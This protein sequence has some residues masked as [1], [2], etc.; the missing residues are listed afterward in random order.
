MTV[1]VRLAREKKIVSRARLTL[2]GHRSAVAQLT[3]ATGH[4]MVLLVQVGFVSGHR[5]TTCTRPA[6]VTHTCALP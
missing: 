4:G 5:S 6:W 2:Y 1:T 3:K